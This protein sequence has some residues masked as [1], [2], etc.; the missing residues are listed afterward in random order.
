MTDCFLYLDEAGDFACGK[1]ASEFATVG[2]VYVIDRDPK[3]EEIRMKRLLNRINAG[4]RQ[5]NKKIPEFRFSSNT[6]KIKEKALRGMSELDINLGIMGISKDSV[7]VALQNDSK[8]LYRH[9]LAESI[10]Q[11]VDRHMNNGKTRNKLCITIDKSLFKREI[12]PFNRSLKDSLLSRIRNANPVTSVDIMIRHE[13]SEKIPMLQVADYVASA[14]YRKI[15]RGNSA[16]YN[17][18]SS[19][20]KYRTKWDRNSKINW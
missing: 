6:D 14:T 20:I 13:D 9:S 3:Q 18:I 4:I 1:D 5:P 7:A 2:I 15:A 16:Y 19:K 8:L 10:G 11:L 12:T 17:M